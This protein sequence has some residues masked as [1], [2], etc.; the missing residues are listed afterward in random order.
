M[1]IHLP[2]FKFHAHQG[3]RSID[4]KFSGHNEFGIVKIE[5]S[6]IERCLFSIHI[7]GCPHVLTFDR[8]LPI[9]TVQRQIGHRT[10]QLCPESL[11]SV[12]LEAEAQINS[13]ICDT[14]SAI[15]EEK[16]G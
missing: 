16:I 14:S 5:L 8:Q 3:N 4:T 1:D 12:C 6:Q 11:G 13:R 10:L 15:W 2:A 7:Q 9:C